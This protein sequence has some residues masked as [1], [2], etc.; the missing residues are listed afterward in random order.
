MMLQGDSQ[1]EH[2][3]KAGVALAMVGVVIVVLLV[4]VAMRF[5]PTGT[6][7]SHLWRMESINVNGK[8]VKISGSAADTED[9][10]VKLITMEEENGV[11]TLVVLGT[12]RKPWEKNP[13]KLYMDATYHF[14]HTIRLVKTKR[15]DILWRDSDQEGVH[16]GGTD[17]TLPAGVIERAQIDLAHPVDHVSGGALHFADADRLILSQ[18]PYLIVFDKKTREVICAID[19]TAIGMS[20]LRGGN[21]SRVSV[22]AD[23]KTVFLHP[24]N[25]E[26]MYVLDVETGSLSQQT[27][28]EAYFTGVT[29]AVPIYVKESRSEWNDTYEADG[30][31][32]YVS[33]HFG[34]RVGEVTF[35]EGLF[36]DEA[37]TDIYRCDAYQPLFYPEG[38]EDAVP[39]TPDDLHDLTEVAMRAGGELVC[40]RDE[41]V[42]DSIET[43][44]RPAKMIDVSGCPFYDPMYFKRADGTTGYILPATDSCNAFVAGSRCY[45]WDAPDN[46]DFW[47][48]FPEILSRWEGPGLPVPVTEE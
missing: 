41:T 14:D 17:E 38:Y 19:R 46:E 37:E 45:E 44:L 23:G 33:L 25:D 24:G 42:L 47:T 9:T 13:G 5:Y 2:N 18:G 39:F 21:H 20:E 36:G 40:V 35:I 16:S 15:G 4:F 8:D 29:G 34:S 22:S 27:Y 7:V 12:K 6:D 48:L 28:Q 3:I 31:S 26:R 43:M 32:Y 10:V 1:K 30:H 11:A